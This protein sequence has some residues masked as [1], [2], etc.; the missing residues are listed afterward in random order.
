MRKDDKEFLIG[1]IRP[2]GQR[3]GGLEKRFDGVEGEIRGLNSRMGG[4]ENR[5]DGLEKRFDGLEIRFDG[6]TTEFRYQGVMLEHIQDLISA[7]A[8]N[9][10]GLDRRLTR[11]EKVLD[12]D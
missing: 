12:L 2:L 7:V 6:L 1:L 8:E 10:V 11:V 4:L 3:L 5:F 9:T